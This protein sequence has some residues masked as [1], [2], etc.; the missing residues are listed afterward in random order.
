[1]TDQCF[2]CAQE[3]N[4]STRK[5]I[6]CPFGCEFSSCKECVRTFL[7]GSASD[8]KCM[9]CNKAFDDK[10]LADN[11]N[12]SFVNTDYKKHRKQFLLEGEI[13]KLHLIL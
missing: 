11:L 5:K 7:L 2:C 13:S 10:F 1:M 4:N 12:K 8:P 3:Y 6:T 9:N